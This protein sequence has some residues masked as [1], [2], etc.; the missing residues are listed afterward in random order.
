MSASEPSS[1]H[2][3]RWIVLA[4][5]AVLVAL[6]IA[7]A[8]YV[9][10]L[11]QPQ[12]FTALLEN[13][14]AAAGLRLN[15]Q[16]PAEPALFPRPAVQLQAFS[17]SIIGSDTPVLQATGATIVVPWRALLRGEVA[18]ERIDV[19]GPRIDLG[20]IES[21]LAHLP[22]RAD[23]PRAPRLP[24]IATGVQLSHGILARNGSPLLFD[25][26][27]QT[28][29]LAPG[30]PF[31]LDASARTS[32][33]RKFVVSVDTVP[34]ATHDGVIDLNPL[35]V[36]FASAGVALALEGQGSWRGG[37][38]LVLNL[39]GTLRHPAPA[40]PAPV[41][42]ATVANPKVAK[43]SSAGTTDAG[44][45]VRPEALDK[46]ALIVE[47]A[48][49]TMPLSAT[50]KLTGEDV[51]VDMRLQPT[52]FASWWSRLLTAAPGRPP[53]PLPFSGTAKLRELDLEGFKAS[54]IEIEATPGP[55]VPAAAASTVPASAASAASSVP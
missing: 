54:G 18:I 29:A 9:H 27:L 24:T 52:E 6:A 13:D 40:A 45:R 2:L 42:A 17:L 4:I 19:D 26:S 34:S 7:L 37:A 23:T 20:E 22:R 33:G 51:H 3:L 14:L 35:Q 21:L 50:V 30:K 12:R 44:A 47:P 10:G 39:D 31:R 16:E 15:M 43:A 11:L 55:A 32:G 38:D 25:F 5:V 48:H 53:A 8:V 1:R 28:G 36:Q 41:A 46:I 49:D